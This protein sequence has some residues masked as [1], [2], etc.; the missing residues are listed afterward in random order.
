MRKFF[1]VAALFISSQ[2][3]AQQDTSSSTL[4]GVIITA[5]KFPKR[6]NETGKVVTVIGKEI[7]EKSSGKTVAELL[8]QQAGIIVVGA[9][10]N[11]GT[12]QD[13]YVRGAA[14]GKTLILIDGI[15]AYDPSTISTPFDLN[16][17]SIDNVERIEIVKGAQSTLYGSDAV[18]G[19][20][21]II[22]KKGGNKPVNL[23]S[24]LSGGSYGTY[25]GAI[26]IDGSIKSSEYNF[27]YTHI[28][29]KG[30]SAAYDSTGTN[31][32]DRDAFK[33][34]VI[35][36]SFGSALS[37]KIKLRFYGQYS[38]YKTDLDAGAFTDDR[39]YTVTTTNYL[40]GVSNTINYTKGTVYINYNYNVTR[41]NYLDDS[42]SV[43]AFAFA[44]YS[45]QKYTGRSHF[46]EVYTIYKAGSHIDILTGA[47]YR[48]QNTDQY[49]FSISSYGPY[50]SKLGADSTK[51]SQ[52]SIFASLMLKNL[53]GFFLESGGRYNHH[54]DYGNNFTYSFNP[55]Y[56]IKTHVK[57][58]ANLASGFKAPS[59][60]QIYSTGKKTEL[61]PEK[62]ISIEGGAQIIAT[63][64]FWARGVYFYNDIRNGIDYSYVTFNYFN[65]NIQKDHGLELETGYK[66]NKFS[67]TANYTYVTGQVNTAKYKYDAATYSYVST[68][69]TSFNNL[70]RRP[71]NSL[72]ATVS[73]MPLDEWYISATT[74]IVGK[75]REAVF[76]SDPVQLDGYQIFDVYT[77]YRIK[78]Q[79]KL[80]IDLKNITNKKYFD[81]W[82]YNSRRFN[83]MA[84]INI[85]L[86]K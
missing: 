4:N 1:A 80:F 48:F 75:R 26:G 61:K 81:I 64:N 86:S 16:N 22:T 43:P 47:D 6:Q 55:S 8:N 37:S 57:L 29:S 62:S 13:V 41:R 24:T 56:L 15:P 27:H 42:I 30:F 18:A 58:F 71:K 32:F 73:Y 60:Y 35:N 76:G 70:F 45:R 46:A 84:G 85:N 11:L 68:G 25:K 66:K 31:N 39:D 77:E 9:Q 14:L 50:E 54:S 72:N 74:K 83:F 10:N 5:N 59:L 34:D 53:N 33:Q 23:Y 40:A 69:D 49:Y 82:G 12:N 3:F 51:S 2:L 38:K 36:G 28:N 79:L 65:H 63:K 52:S 67:V 17:I 44:K 21:N 7:L 20:I 19:V 78:K